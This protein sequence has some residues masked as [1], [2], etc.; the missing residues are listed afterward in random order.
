MNYFIALVIVAAISFVAGLFVEAK[1]G[2]I[3]QFKDK[4]PK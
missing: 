4:L 1:N 2:L 3:A